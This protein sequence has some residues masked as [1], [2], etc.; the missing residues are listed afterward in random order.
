MTMPIKKKC[1]VC[2]KNSLETLFSLPKLPLT[3]LY[4][5]PGQKMK[6]FKFNQALQFCSSCGHAQLKNILNP[7]ILYNET[8]TH[9]SGQSSL[10]RMG[11]DFFFSF[12]KLVAPK[13]RFK[14]VLEVGANDLYLLKKVK[15]LANLLL[16]VDP[17]W[18]VHK[19][20]IDSKIL[21]SGE[22]IESLNTKEFLNQGPDLIISAHTFEHIQNPYVVLKKIYNQAQEGALFVIEVPCLDTQILNSRFDQVFHQ[23]LQYFSVYSMKKMIQQLGASFKAHVFNQ[24]YWGG[25]L[26]VAFEK[27]T[28]VSKNHFKLTP[29]PFYLKKKFIQSK[30][31]LFQKKMR[32]LSA[33]LRE[34]TTKPLY[35]YGAA[36]MLPVLAYHLKNNL[37]TFEAIL[38]DNP[39]RFGL[40]YPGLRVLIKKPAKNLAW[41][42][43]RFFITA[44]DSQKAI[45][46]RLV[47]LKAAKV[48]TALG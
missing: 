26:L 17:I 16:G 22:F 18:R 48:I 38:D 10:A 21:V 19:K 35:G 9:R 4:I 8:Y 1:S 47:H 36:Q 39:A 37:S 46:K 40:A 41:K 34:K 6:N 43:S 7:K 45:L 25:T 33:S 27:K 30:Y 42:Q 32:K 11:N 13:R 12:L 31:Q 28:K 5:K 2:Q 3:G 20:R 24:D 14:A 29:K 23:H 15:P 44:L